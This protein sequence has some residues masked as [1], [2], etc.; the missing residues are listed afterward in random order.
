M[1][2][3]QKTGISLIV[4]VITIIVMLI[5]AGA[6]ILALNN[7]NIIDRADEAATKSNIANAKQVAVLAKAEYELMSNV[8]RGEVTLRNYIEDKLEEAGLKSEIDKVIDGEG[9]IF[10]KTIVE[11]V[12]IPE[13]F[14]YVG[15]TKAGGLV[16]SDDFADKGKGITHEK[17]IELQG[18]QFVWVPV[19]NFSEFVRYD[20]K[21]NTTLNVSYK[22]IVPEVGKDREVEKMYASV[23]KYKGFYVGRYETG[24][25]EGMEKPTGSTLDLADGT[26]RPQIKQGIDVWNRIPW[27]G[28][29]A[30]EAY[31]GYQGNDSAN[32]AVKV[33]RSMYPDNNKNI[34][35]V[36]STLI[37]G[38]Q[39]DAIVRW[40]KASGINIQDSS[41][42]GNYAGGGGLKVAGAESNY[43]KNNIYDLAGNVFEWT[44]EANGS[45]Y[46][47]NRGGLSTVNGADYPVSY[48]SNSAPS[49]WNFSVGFRVVAY[50]K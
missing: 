1:K 18:N 32:G 44:M 39:W 47:I 35:G 41:A 6:I 50:I 16:I 34:T 45:T 24:I 37:Y 48:R 4:L 20:F 27:G 30:V 3:N 9:N 46:R 22:E 36:V 38:V 12:V 29:E 40:Y 23:K 19:E 49:Y 7:A 5:L 15:G 33:A 10:T 31:D 28:T 11:G 43:Q 26:N 14:Y 25:A 2:T 21:N 17:A 13:G 8:E 42:Y